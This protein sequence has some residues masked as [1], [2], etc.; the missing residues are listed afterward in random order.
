V[1]TIRKIARDSGTVY[2]A[3]IIAEARDALA[4]AETT[5]K[6]GARSLAIVPEA[7]TLLQARRE[8]HQGGKVAALRPSGL[9]FP[10]KVTASKPVSLRTPWETALKRAGIDG[11]RW[12]D[13][14]HSAAGFLAK[15]G[16]S[17]VEIGAV[18][19]GKLPRRA[20]SMVLEW[21]AIHRTELVDN[22]TRAQQRKPLQPIE[23]LD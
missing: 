13:M 20:L 2:Q 16:A 21:L 6:G 19:A 7:L 15:D 23:P 9:V 12:H 17:L 14:R 4:D 18:L 8:A 1:A 11:F 22:W 5:T 10:S 3:H